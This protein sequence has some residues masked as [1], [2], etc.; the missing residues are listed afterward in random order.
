MEV[1]ADKIEVLLPIIETTVGL[2][3]S[4]LKSPVL[5]EVNDNKKSGSPYVLTISLKITL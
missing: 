2:R 1:P 5:E 4:K 3:G